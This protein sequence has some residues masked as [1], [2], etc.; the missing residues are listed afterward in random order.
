[1]VDIERPSSPK[2]EPEISPWSLAGLGVQFA[3]ALVFFGY[4]GQWLDQRLNSAPAFLLIGVMLGAGGTFYLS[5]RNLTAPKSRKKPPVD[6]PDGA[7]L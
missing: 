5:Y 1:M 4:A 6:P 3:V 7:G 2:P